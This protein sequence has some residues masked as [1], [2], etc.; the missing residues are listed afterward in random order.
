MCGVR[1][2]GC[3]GG[4]YKA[5]LR[6][7]SSRHVGLGRLRPKFG[8]GASTTCT[9]RDVTGAGA[10]AAGVVLSEAPQQPPRKRLEPSNGWDVA[11]EL[12]DEAIRPAVLKPGEERERGQRC[13]DVV[14]QGVGADRAAAAPQGRG[15]G[16]R[17]ARRSRHRR[18]APARS[19]RRWVVP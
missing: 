5:E 16:E 13:R 17:A 7:E 14:G 3:G 8:A 6:L 11:V 4:T 2:R 12:P 15:R 1:V 9:T 10:P 18:Q 19:Q